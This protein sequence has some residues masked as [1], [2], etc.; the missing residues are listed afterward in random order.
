MSIPL[1]DPYYRVE[2]DAGPYS[3]IT[4]AGDVADYGLADPLNVGWAL[5]GN[6]P[7]FH[8]QPEPMVCSFSVVEPTMA[9]L[10]GLARGTTVLVK[11]WGWPPGTVNPHADTVPSG[12]PPGDLDTVEYTPLVIF[13]GRIADVDARPHRLG[14][15]ATC[16]CVDF[17]VDLAESTI[18]AG[19]WP[20]EPVEDRLDRMFTEAGVLP[21]TDML[22]VGFGMAARTASPGDARSLVWKVADYLTL[23][24]DEPFGVY[25]YMTTRYT[26]GFLD[27]VTPDPLSPY[28]I[29]WVL[30]RYASGDDGQMPR[31][32][33]VFAETQPGL[34]G[35]DIVEDAG[36]RAPVISADHVDF[37]SKWNQSKRTEPDTI[38]LT[39]AF[40]DPVTGIIHD[41]WT[42]AEPDAV[43]IAAQIPA[44]FDSVY[45]A[46]DFG[47]ANLSSGDSDNWNADTFTWYA[48]QDPWPMIAAG[49]GWFIEGAHPTA[50]REPVVV[51]GI[52]P[53]KNPTGT[54]WFAGRL[55][56]A[57]FTLSGGHYTVAFKLRRSLLRPQ[58]FDVSIPG[59]GTHTCSFQDLKAAHPLLDWDDL[60]PTYSWFDARLL[61]S[62]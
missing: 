24:P 45:T 17:T 13:R 41:S 48:D 21:P 26:A 42:V 59:E 27:G 38:T 39:G 33:G 57:I 4:E 28:A 31:L 50:P 46:Q 56:S 14:M 40:L 52:D 10:A 8:S 29:P 61:R 19:D 1:T 12:M 7:L 55:A 6:D 51:D 23:T 25:H 15:I 2:V 53:D 49:G 9:D 20:A 58:V 5:P 11:V 30:A 22:L 37:D 60:D 43:P 62:P 35:V 18:G 32:P 54:D 34:W 44:E 47:L 16:A 3:W 36:R